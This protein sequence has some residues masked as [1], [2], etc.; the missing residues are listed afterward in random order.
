MLINFVRSS[1][2]VYCK[3]YWWW[4]IAIRAPFLN[5]FVQPP[6][7][8]FKFSKFAFERCM[9]VFVCVFSRCHSYKAV[10]MIAATHGYIICLFKIE[11]RE[12]T[13]M[14]GIFN[15][16]LST[17]ICAWVN[18]PLCCCGDGA[19]KVKHCCCCCCS[20]MIKYVLYVRK[21]LHTDST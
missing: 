11:E 2:S 1:I 20:K 19:N 16:N 15:E 17:V 3:L 6:H 7:K 8:T 14:F 4:P 10:A 21:Y 12:K 5:Y 13:L 9:C 18:I